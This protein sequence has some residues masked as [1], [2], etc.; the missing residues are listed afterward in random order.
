MTGIITVIHVGHYL[1][2]LAF[3]RAD[4]FLRS[5]AIP[6]S[7]DGDSGVVAAVVFRHSHSD[8]PTLFE[9]ARRISSHRRED[10][11]NLDAVIESDTQAGA[12]S[13]R[14][15][16]AATLVSDGAIANCILA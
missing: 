12:I 6:S 5:P 9:T 16:C 10:D 15:H 3:L 1:H 2:A 4:R 7:S 11:T 8:D 13:M 14:S